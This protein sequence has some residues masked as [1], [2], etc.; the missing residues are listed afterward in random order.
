VRAVV[1]QI[2]GRQ[3]HR[4]LDPVRVLGDVGGGQVRTVGVPHEDQALCA[5]A[6]MHVLQVGH[7]ERGRVTARVR[8]P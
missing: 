8:Q 3:E 5:D 1:A 4:A 7:P 6:L 2:T